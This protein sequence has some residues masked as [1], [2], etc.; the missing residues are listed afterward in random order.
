MK[1][2]TVHTK[3]TVASI[4]KP[5]IANATPIPVKDEPI[6]NAVET[7][8]VSNAL[9][10]HLPIAF[11]AAAIPH[12]QILPLKHANPHRH[13]HVKP[14]VK[15][16]QLNHQIDR[17]AMRFAEKCGLTSSDFA[18][19]SQTSQV[20]HSIVFLIIYSYFSRITCC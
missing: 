13:M 8:G 18:H 10:E 12:L 16:N 14:S 11:P 5:P 1:K 4:N 6:S 2:V 19:P 17:F 9:N 20:L 3:D 7:P 15:A